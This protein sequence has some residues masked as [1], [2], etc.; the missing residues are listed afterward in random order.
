MINRLEPVLF[1]KLL[2]IGWML[3]WA[4]AFLTDFLGGLKQLGL[5]HYDWVYNGN[6]PFLVEC[7]TMYH[8]PS[9]IPIFLY[10]GIIFWLFLSTIAFIYAC[11][12]LRK[13]PVTWKKRA[14]VAFMISILLWVAFF[15]GDQIVMKFDLEENHMV[16]ASMEFISYL[17]LFLLPE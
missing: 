13:D 15:L 14:S 9:W 10:S 17:S 12:G 16:Q 3:W 5:V 11:A 1:K 4:I 6:Y 8:V 2:I 7:L